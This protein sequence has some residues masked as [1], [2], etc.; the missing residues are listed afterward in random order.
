MHHVQIVSNAVIGS[1]D[2]LYL[3][4]Y[5]PR[6][7]PRKPYPVLVYIHGGGFEFGMG[8]FTG[9]PGYFMDHNIVVVTLN[10]RLGL[11]GFLSMEDSVLSGNMGLK[12]QNMALKWIQRNIKNF[13]GDAKRVTI[14]GESAGG[15]SVY[16]H[17]I[18]PWSK[19]LFHQGISQ[20][21]TA[22]TPW[23][24]SA[25]GVGRARAIKIAKMAGCPTKNT[26]SMLNCLQQLDGRDLMRLTKHFPMNQLEMRPTFTP[27]VDS[28]AKDP[29]LPEEPHKLK[30]LPVPWLTGCSNMEGIIKTAHFSKFPNHY[31][32]MDSKFMD[33]FPTFLFNDNITVSKD[34]ALKIRKYYF[35]NESITPAMT[36]NMT[37][38]SLSFLLL[39]YYFNYFLNILNSLMPPP[40]P[41]RS[42]SG[43]SNLG[44]LHG[45]SMRMENKSLHIVFTLEQK[46][47]PPL[48]LNQILIP[49]TYH[50]RYFGLFLD[51]RLRLEP[52]YMP[53]TN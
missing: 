31:N 22:L 43:L 32:D 48:F 13:G 25:P 2:C 34:V 9:R 5:T 23:A 20:S 28:A 30:P 21:G 14:Y 50:V 42:T 6:L 8:E 29:F 41:C 38:A 3:S 45:E 52:S 17:M 11:M 33:I 53:E 1:E 4:I 36:R 35:G 47:S 27:I 16:Y 49:Q 19:G 15:A 10:Y 18:S 46:N 40:A 44:S 12:D 37:N 24:S 26:K 51:K 7:N 39:F